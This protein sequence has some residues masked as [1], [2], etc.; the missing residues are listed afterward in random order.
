[1]VNVDVDVAVVGGG[2]AGH[3][4][5]L[6]AAARGGRVALVEGEALGGACVH[7]TC[8]PSGLMLSAAVPLVEL[9]ELA[10]A[11]VL[12]LGDRLDLA[13]AQARRRALATR[14]ARSV[15]MSL[16]TAGVL[17]VPGRATLTGPGRL[18]VAAAG[19]VEAWSAGAT[20]VA[21]G[22]RWEAPRVPGVPDTRVVTLDAVLALDAAP[23]H[24]LVLAGGPP[25]TGFSVESAFL[26][27]AAGSEVVLAAPGARLVEALDP[28]VDEL[29]RSALGDMAIRVLTGAR[30]EAAGATEGAGAVVVHAGGEEPA[31]EAL[32]VAPDLRRP[33]TASLGL[34]AAGVA[35]GPDGT[36]TVDERCR[37]SVAGVLAAGDVTGGPMVTAA[38]QM[39][40]RVAGAN[41][42]GDDERVAGIRADSL[43]RVLHGVPGLAWVGLGEEA[44]TR[45]GWDVAVAM[46]DL[47]PS[48]RATV[49][50]GR[51]GVL[52]LVADR[53]LGQVLGVQVIGPEV[54]EIIAVAAFAI[55]AELTVDDL[56]AS[57]QWH[58]SAA[59]SLVEA[60]RRLAG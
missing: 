22:S 56:A 1:M 19:G 49:L 9:R 52:K 38:A 57:A 51:E 32:V 27:A 48:A 60:A 41:A 17:V 40:G 16:S 2:P 21:T 14:L 11:G 15:E 24:A 33:D 42:A 30:V 36:V 3:A 23:A 46:L 13:R 54:A 34:E 50:G 20:V 31:S 4:A 12:D 8:I 43:P 58:P 59:E 29:F 44:A 28:E 26:L 53:G 55:Q 35:L 25:G 5:A 47:G 10:T 7:S 37:T 39:A 45:A 18:E 6:A